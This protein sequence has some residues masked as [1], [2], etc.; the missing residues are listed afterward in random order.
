[1]KIRLATSLPED[2]TRKLVSLISSMHA[3]YIDVP[4]GMSDAAGVIAPAGDSLE[5]SDG[6][7]VLAGEPT[8]GGVPEIVGPLAAASP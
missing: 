3:I 7:G 6:D 8:G 2:S 4:E 5:V 1:M